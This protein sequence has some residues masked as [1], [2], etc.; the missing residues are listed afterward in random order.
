MRHGQFV[1]PGIQ[2]LPVAVLLSYGTA[3]LVS[4]NGFLVL[5][6]AVEGVPKPRQCIRLTRL[7]ACF[8]RQLQRPL[9]LVE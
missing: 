6:A 3:L 1:E 2:A 5:P 8:L 4:L 9:P 7:V